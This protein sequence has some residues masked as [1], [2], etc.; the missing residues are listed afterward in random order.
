MF[1][2]DVVSAWDYAEDMVA[3]SPSR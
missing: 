1:W 3:V 2:H